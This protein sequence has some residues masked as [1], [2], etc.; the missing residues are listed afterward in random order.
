MLEIL[1]AGFMAIGIIASSAIALTLLLI[2]L[3]AIK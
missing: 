3:G 2:V 1:M